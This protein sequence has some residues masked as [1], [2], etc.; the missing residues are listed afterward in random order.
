MDTS[1]FKSA[2]LSTFHFDTNCILCRDRHLHIASLKI[3]N[4]EV[5]YPPPSN[6]M[7]VSVTVHSTNH[8]T[9]DKVSRSFVVNVKI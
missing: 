5:K 1:I 2:P 3:P 7:N 9:E 6:T 8:S 4:C